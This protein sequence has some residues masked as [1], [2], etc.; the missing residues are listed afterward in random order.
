MGAKYSRPVHR[1]VAESEAGELTDKVVFINR[2]AKVVKGGRRFSFSALVVSGDENGNVGYGLGKANEVP[3]AIRKGSEAARK[4]LISVPLVG[5]T[6]PFEV[7]GYNGSAKVLLKPASPGTG[8]IAGSAVR[9]VLELVGVKDI[10]TKSFGS[11][12]PHNVLAAVFEGLLQLESPEE[13]AVRRNKQLE[14]MD[15]QTFG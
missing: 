5:A 12:N 3:D 8:V 4:A 13:V 10:L 1:K 14:G 2:V 11:Q 9:S 7:V 6:V 15:Y